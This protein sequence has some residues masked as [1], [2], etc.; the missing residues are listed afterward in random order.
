MFIKTIYKKYNLEIVDHFSQDGTTP[1]LS[2]EIDQWNEEQFK[3]WCDY[4][5]SICR[6]KSILG[7]SNHVIIVGKK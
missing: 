6:E 3:V 5:Y 2:H 7:S 4:H 1:L